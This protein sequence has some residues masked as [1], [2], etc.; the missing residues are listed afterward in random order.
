MTETALAYAFA[1]VWLAMNAWA[2]WVVMSDRYSEQHQKGFQ[3]AAVWLVPIFGL[4]FIFALHRKPEPPTG[5][6]RQSEAPPWDDITTTQH[7]GRAIDRTV[8]D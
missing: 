7:I 4:I 6:Y 3:L 2:T 1:A 8:G 5:T